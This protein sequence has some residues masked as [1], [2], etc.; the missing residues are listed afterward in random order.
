VA[1]TLNPAVRG[2]ELFAA[3][4]FSRPTKNVGLVQPWSPVP[5]ERTSTKR[6]GWSR[7][8]DLNRWPADYE[9][10]AASP[11]RLTPFLFSRRRSP[12]RIHGVLILQKWDSRQDS[13]L[14]LRLG[15]VHGCYSPSCFDVP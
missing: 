15:A 3:E 10:A 13:K 8:S 1:N 9:F 5:T 12:E 14:L 7:R 6:K 4:R 2:R 11:S